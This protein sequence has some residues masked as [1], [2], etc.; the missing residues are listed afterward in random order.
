MRDGP[1][2][3]YGGSGINLNC[4]CF[5][6]RAVSRRSKWLIGSS[7]TCANCRRKMVVIGEKLRVPK[8]ADSKG[9]KKLEELVN[10]HLQR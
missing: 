8:K 9:W 2:Y 3:G 5:Q 7:P 6:C 4:V 10:K 1:S